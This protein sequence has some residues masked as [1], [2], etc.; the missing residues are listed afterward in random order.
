VTTTKQILQIN[1]N[2]SLSTNE[3]AA[4]FGPLADPISKVPGLQWKFWLL[5][6]DKKESGGIYLFDDPESVQSYLDGP[7]IAGVKQHPALSNINVKTFGIVEELSRITR[8]P[9]DLPIPA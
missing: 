4:A 5:N 8:A 2:Y 9:I 7:I 6:E 1:F 3:L